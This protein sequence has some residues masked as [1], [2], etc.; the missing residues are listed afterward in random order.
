[1]EKIKY[2]VLWI[3]DEEDTGMFVDRARDTFG[4]DIHQE[5][6]YF[7]G[8]KYLKENLKLIDA[9]ILDVNC[10]I[11]KE[12]APNMGSFEDRIWS[13]NK[14]CRSEELIPWFVYTGGGYEGF[15]ALLPVIRSMNKEWDKENF[16][17]DKSTK[18]DSMFEAIINEAN[19]RHSTTLRMKYHELFGVDEKINGNLQNILE[20]LESNNVCDAH[21]FEEIRAALETLRHKMVTSCILPQELN[22]NIKI[23]RAKY[24]IIMPEMQK[25][26]PSYIQQSYFSSVTITN[27]ASHNGKRE[28]E[29]GDE[30]WMDSENPP[31]ARKDVQEGRAPYLRTSVA[32]AFITFLFWL[33]SLECE[34]ENLEA[35]R[36]ITEKAYQKFKRN[37]SKSNKSIQEEKYDFVDKTFK[38]E[39]DE[40]GIF[41]CGI[42]EIPSVAARKFEGKEVTLTDVSENKSYYR[43]KYPYFAKFKPVQ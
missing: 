26:I 5:F 33:A 18:P 31:R 43:N 4:I 27:E 24:F 19:K 34:P 6:C 37:D 29:E 7:S 30:E 39:M 2:K 15:A 10:K 32:N 35:R 20:L 41:H 3:D 25:I 16:Y 40:S 1:M 13:I 21:I 36:T 12:N 8:E 38:I 23:N 22:E 9:V 17:Y 42:C 11:K 28:S 14:L